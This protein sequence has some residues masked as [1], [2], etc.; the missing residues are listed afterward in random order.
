MGVEKIDG[1]EFSNSLESG[2]GQIKE[3]EMK[4]LKRLWK[5]LKITNVD[6]MLIGFLLFILGISFVF[7]AAEPEVKTY[8]DALWYAFS[9]ITTIGF[10]DYYAVTAVG[11][12]CTVVLG[13]YGILIV[14][15]IPGVVV[16]YY[17]EFIQ[18]KMDE[19]AGVFLEKLDQLS[20]E[21]LRDISEKIKK[22]R[23]K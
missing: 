12:I 7:L 2:I 4:K 16:S 8:G 22:G 9:V 3:Y 5:I 21:E 20:K 6:K 15:L 10:G 11:R 19:T 18:N 23:Y 13:L 17:L 14:A 1:N